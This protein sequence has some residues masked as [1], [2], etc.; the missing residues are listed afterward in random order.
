[1]C[2]AC[3]QLIKLSGYLNPGIDSTPVHLRV[4]PEPSPFSGP[5]A[6]A[7]TPSLM[8][9][10]PNVQPMRSGT[11]D[12]QFGYGVPNTPFPMAH[13]NLSPNLADVY[14]ICREALKGE[15][16][17]AFHSGESFDH[18]GQLGKGGMGVVY[19]VIDKRL[20]RDAALKVL[21]TA[22]TELEA[23]FLREAKITAKLDHPSIPPVYEIGKF[24]NGELYL[25]MRVI[26]GETLESFIQEYSKNRKPQ[27]LR[28][29]LEVMI[30]VCE[31]LAYAHSQG[32]L[33]RDLKP[34]N[35]MVGAFGEVLVMDW[36]LAKQIGSET[37]LVVDKNAE[38][39][40]EIGL[41]QQGTIL[42][43]LGYMPPEQVDGDGVD[44]RSD[45][46][47]L[48]A[49]LTEVLTGRPP[50]DGASNINRL[51]ATLKGKIAGPLDRDKSIPK[52]LDYI[53]R[54]ALEVVQENRTC[55]AT[56]F[57]NQL[58]AF[59]LNEPVCGYS[60]PFRERSRRFIGRHAGILLSGAVGALFL[61]TAAA[62]YLALQNEREKAKSA[63]KDAAAKIVKT[64]RELDRAKI[65]REKAKAVLSL[66]QK[67]RQLLG[68]GGSKE[69]ILK[70][71]EAG[72]SA[73]DRSQTSLLV[74]AKI[75]DVANFNDEQEALLTEAIR[76]HSPA[77]E[78]LFNLHLLT[79]KRERRDFYFTKA[80][81]DLWELA[82][83]RGDE[84]EFTLF[85]RAMTLQAEG[86][87][88]RALKLYD[89]IESDHTSTF[90]WMYVNRGKLREEL[91]DDEGAR[92][93]YD[94]A[95]SL[96][97]NFSIAYNNRGS[98]R[99]DCGDKKGALKDYNKALSINSRDATAFVT[100]GLLRAEFGDKKGAFEDYDQAI[101][102]DPK[103][104]R[105]Y[106]SRGLL[107]SGSGNDDGALQDYNKA[108]SLD[109][110]D[111]L[112]Y[113]NRGVLRMEK[114]DS[115]GALKDFTIA[116]SVD[117]RFA[118]AYVH[119][120]N[121]YIAMR[122][123]TA[124]LKDYNK[125]ISIDANYDT[126][127]FDRGNL[128]KESGKRTAALKD[129]NKAI[130]INPLFVKAYINRGLLLSDMGD[131]RGALR[132]YDK[133]ISLDSTVSSAYNNRGNL[134]SFMND[135]A[136]ALKDFEKAIAINPNSAVTYANR[137]ILYM[138]Q[139][140][141]KLAIND[142]KHFLSLQPNHPAAQQF[143]AY[144]QKLTKQLEK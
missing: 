80:L 117:P 52:D 142:M 21:K 137:G 126:V 60:Y 139:G 47:A 71:I 102:V 29:L 107:K 129:Y 54:A 81:K 125:A 120:G 121:L 100:R 32:F 73:G 3:K 67:A 98:L 7:P 113:N 103:N 16:L 111:V 31:A 89:K 63:K 11:Q 17:A 83:K 124:A 46:F 70:T 77:Y 86:D 22:S 55:S 41:T 74:A 131:R 93:D 141:S 79:L 37:D 40:E 128:W 61:A 27:K 108:I 88:E 78:A 82:V 49:I 140:K 101:S 96:D 18:K 39:V 23:R 97:S 14:A 12:Q 95:I 13:G 135:K 30:K 51:N 66:F 133:A 87:N 4:F 114:G 36:G 33:H 134:R 19:R 43:T 28:P 64:G 91:K 127:Y 50:I 8:P 130:L 35:I 15:P 144:I 2:P 48:G 109:P 53:A 76:K 106:S 59:L 138:K 42:G 118:M 24:E 57:A 85:S 34:A 44:Q 56:D 72:L 92:E 99:K 116:I 5:F 84:N 10:N 105:A 65:E 122:N 112:T 9:A 1:M 20:D 94:K 62:S 38:L 104:A 68:R 45:V 132:D 123:R 75:C 136:G 90:T 110:K 69:K 25:L 143:R 115:N 6:G 58:K 26:E 119:R